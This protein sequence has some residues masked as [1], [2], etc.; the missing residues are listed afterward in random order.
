MVVLEKEDASAA[1][2]H[3]LDRLAEGSTL[4]HLTVKFIDLTRGSFVVIAPESATHSHRIDFQS[5]NHALRG[6]EEIRFARLLKLF[7]R[8]PDCAVVLQELHATL[9]DPWMKDFSYRHLAIQCGSE[10]Y[11]RV[12]GKDLSSLS[13]ESI[14]EVIDAA[15][16]FP[17]TAFFYVDGISLN[18][19]ELE[20]VDLRH[21]VDKIVAIAVSAFDYRSYLIWWNEELRALPREI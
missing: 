10:L 9:S 20:T 19:A 1:A 4:A 5:S 11:W 18:K 21:V 2:K 17:F 7:I 3:M 16:P 12:S 6:D 13:D 14:E 8:D 15:S